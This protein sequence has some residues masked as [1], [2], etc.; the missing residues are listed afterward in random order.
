MQLDKS[1]HTKVSKE[2]EMSSEVDKIIQEATGIR[3]LQNDKTKEVKSE[4]AQEAA[5]VMKML[6]EKEDKGTK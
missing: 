5:S 6:E 2:S 4:A 1:H 3:D